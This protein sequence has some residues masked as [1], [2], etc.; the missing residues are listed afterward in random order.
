MLILKKNELKSRSDLQKIRNCVGYIAFSKE[1]EGKLLQKQAREL[2][3]LALADNK[4]FLP[5]Q[6]I[7]LCLADDNLSAAG[8]FIQAD[9]RV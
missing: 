9:G 8:V 1:L 5:R 6:R 3:E 2:L 4:G 7:R